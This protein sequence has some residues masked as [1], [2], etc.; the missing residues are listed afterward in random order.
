MNTDAV[1]QSLG[2]L[3]ASLGQPACGTMAFAFV[4]DTIAADHIVANFYG[5]QKIHG[6]FTEGLV[7]E[8]ISRTLNQRYIERYHLLDKSLLSFRDI[9]KGEPIAT[10]FDHRL[11]DSPAY[12]TF[13]FER[14][15][16]CDRISIVSSRDNGMVC[17]NV[18]R[19]ATNGKFNEE[20]MAIAQT[21]ALPLTAALWQHAEK[22]V[23]ADAFVSRPLALE[24]AP[25][26]AVQSLSKRE[27]QVCQR[28]L[29]GAS[30]EGIALDL[31]ISMHTVRTLRKRAYKKLGVGSLADLFAIYM[32]VMTDTHGGSRR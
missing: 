11:N 28:L 30:N 2:N 19:L 4:R 13:F 27:M 20:A 3:I 16:L 15:G 18:Y 21:I 26:L 7:A 24:Q 10:R 31:G 25:H 5:P 29:T 12:S 23:P 9:G 8:R 22:I 6:L 1:Y 17:G 32:H 14:A